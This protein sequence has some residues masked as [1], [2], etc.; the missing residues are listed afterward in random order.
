M[1]RGISGWICG[2]QRR[3]RQFEHDLDLEILGAVAAGVGEVD[4]HVG[5]I[6]EDRGLGRDLRLLARAE[7]LKK[8]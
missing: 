5:Q 4:Q 2:D 6:D 1:T 8:K 3:V 7:P